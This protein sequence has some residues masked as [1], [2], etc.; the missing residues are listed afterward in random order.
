MKKLIRTT[1]ENPTFREL[2]TLLDK[3]LKIRDGEDHAFFAQFNKIDHLNH[4]VVCHLN[5]LPVGCGAFKEYESK[6]VEIKRMF[7]KPDFRGKGIAL[8]ILQ[9]LEKWA[10]ELHYSSA[11]LETGKKQPEAIRL[12]EKAG[13]T[14]I[15][16]YGQYKNI[17]NSV[18]MKR[19]LGASLKT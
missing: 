16:N 19:N 2:V 7:V 17:E 8:L 18:C 4:V 15:E 13:Y 6:T 1:S 11:I 12:Y 14:K 10:T 5:N 3:D 9:E